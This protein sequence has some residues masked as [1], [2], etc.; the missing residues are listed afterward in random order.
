[1]ASLVVMAVVAAATA[2]N[3]ND[4]NSSNYVSELL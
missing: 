3:K 4:K 1:V 2:F